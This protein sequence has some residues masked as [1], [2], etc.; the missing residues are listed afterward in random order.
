[1][2]RPPPPPVW[3]AQPVDSTREDVAPEAEPIADNPS[4]IGLLIVTGLVAVNLIPTLVC[5]LPQSNTLTWIQIFS[6]SVRYLA[7]TTAVGII[8]ISLPWL[9]L[10]AK[11]PFGLAFLSKKVGIGWLLLPCISLLYRQH[12]PWMILV[13]ALATVAVALSLRPIFPIYTE[14]DQGKFAGW[15]T[16][17]LPSLYGLPIGDFRPLRALFIALCAQAAFAL[18]AIESLYFAS[19]LLSASLFLVTWRWRSVRYRRPAKICPHGA[20]RFALRLRPLHHDACAGSLG[21]G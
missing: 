21:S 17:T 11:P 1:M 15:R 10:R 19:I 16:S 9:F 20:A 3:K 14:T 18:A 5:R 12:S 4:D 2:N 7:L 13:V 6:L 8:G